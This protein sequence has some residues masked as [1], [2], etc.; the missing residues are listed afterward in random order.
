MPSAVLQ[1]SVISYAIKSCVYISL[2]NYTVCT[3]TVPSQYKGI[4][5]KCHSAIEILFWFDTEPAS[6]LYSG[7]P[8]VLKV[9]LK[10]KE[11]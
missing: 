8:A 5:P 2:L 7:L 4:G 1:R 9:E 3:D 10:Y 11:D 6:N